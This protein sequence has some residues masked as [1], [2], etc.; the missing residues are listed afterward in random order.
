MLS[1]DGYTIL[2]M[3]RPT[4]ISTLR[5]FMGRSVSH[6]SPSRQRILHEKIT[7]AFFYYR[8]ARLREIFERK[9]YTCC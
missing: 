9:R 8:K 1:P 3:R 5:F 4:T 6:K 7:V 2:P